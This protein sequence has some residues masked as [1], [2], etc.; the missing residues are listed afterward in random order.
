MLRIDKENDYYIDFCDSKCIALVQ[1]VTLT[2]GN[3]KGETDFIVR[4][5]YGSLQQLLNGYAAA[6]SR[7]PASSMKEIIERLKKVQ[8]TIDEISEMT[9]ADFKSLMTEKGK[10]GKKNEDRII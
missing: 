9:K 10:K 6:V 3:R 8:K 2:K 1:K 7:E 4:G 5:Y